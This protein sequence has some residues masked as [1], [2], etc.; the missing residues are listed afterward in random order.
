M[1]RRP[2]H[3]NRRSRTTDSNGRVES[4]GVTRAAHCFTIVDTLLVS[5]PV[6]T[7]ASRGRSPRRADRRHSGAILSGASAETQQTGAACG[8]PSETPTPRFVG[9]YNATRISCTPIKARLLGGHVHTQ[10]RE[11]LERGRVS[12]AC[13]CYTC[14]TGAFRP[15]P[16]ALTPATRRELSARES[17]RRGEARSVG[18]DHS[19]DACSG[20]DDEAGPTAP[21]TLWRRDG[22]LSS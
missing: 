15:R 5:D 1:D 16:E 3:R 6:G 11:H 2:T 4:H 19:A 8:E 14:R 9:L 10:G 21:D 17:G 18:P 22:K 12:A 7:A 20:G 13:A